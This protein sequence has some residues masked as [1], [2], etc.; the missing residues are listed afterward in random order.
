MTEK[1][2]WED[3][4]MRVDGDTVLVG[5]PNFPLHKLSVDAEGKLQLEEFKLENPKSLLETLQYRDIEEE[6]T[7]G[8]ITEGT[9]DK[10]EEYLAEMMTRAR[11]PQEQI[12]KMRASRQE[13]WDEMNKKAAELGIVTTVGAT[14]HAD[15]VL[16]AFA[17][18]A[19][20]FPKQ[21]DLEPLE[22]QNGHPEEQ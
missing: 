21:V 20:S 10:K 8:K 12:A 15:D 3:L 22:Q 17:G 1:I 2:N 11:T 7:S 16:A 13:H 14:M 5:H 9:A 19:E 6:L 4:R 18:L